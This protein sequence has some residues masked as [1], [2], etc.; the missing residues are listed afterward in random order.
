MVQSVAIITGASQGLGAATA[1]RLSKDFTSLVLVARNEA[2]LKQTASQVESAG[3]TALAIPADLTQP[4]AI[5]PIIDQTISKFGRIDAIFNNAGAVPPVD[6]FELT[7]A[8][9]DNSFALKLHGARR[10][11]L[12]AWPYLKE[13][14]GAV[15]F[16]SGVVAHA[17]KHSNA[18]VGVVN[19]AVIALAKA[20][21]DQG[22]ED[23]VQVNS[24]LPGP[25]ETARL[26]TIINEF[27]RQNGLGRE[28]AVKKMLKKS[29]IARYGRPEEIAESVAY[30][31]SPGARWLT[32]SQIRIDGGTVKGL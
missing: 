31:L 15:L 11:T 7:D 20:F 5:K 3:A 18:A 9:W 21:A 30:L 27:A 19:S 23:G 14:K 13:S 28:E 2:N 4:S 17:P 29:Q 32:G 16:M 24:I 12:A 10:L 8:Q 22:I 26:T 6:L 25:V 1:I